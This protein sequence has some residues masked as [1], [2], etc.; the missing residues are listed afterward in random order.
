MQRADDVEESAIEDSLWDK[1]YNALKEDKNKSNRIAEYKELLSRVLV[2]GLHSL[3]HSYLS[4]TTVQRNS[5]IL[6]RR[7]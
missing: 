6:F 2:R 5:S 3:S 1:A 4:R 7:N